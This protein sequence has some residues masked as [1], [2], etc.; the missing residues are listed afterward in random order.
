MGPN[1]AMHHAA[2]AS[3]EFEAALLRLDREEAARLLRSS[4]TGPDGLDGVERLVS[5]SLA[6]IGE[7]WERG[8]VALSQ[9]YMGGRICEELVDEVLPRGAPGRKVQPR[10]AIVVLEDRHALGK[11]I[12][13]SCLRAAG[14]ELTDLGQGLTVEEA[15]ARCREG[16]IELLLVSTLMLPAALRVGALTARLREEGLSTKVMVGGAPFLFDERL[17]REVGAE[18]MGRSAGDAIQL[19]RR[20]AGADA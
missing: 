17:W 8:D 12:V 14:Y 15:V 11:R 18:A 1:A 9:I 3:G 5:S 20:F 19:V 10:L 13:Y 7:A 16:E 4:A 2:E 6:R